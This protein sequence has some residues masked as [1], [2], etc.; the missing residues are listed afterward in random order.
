MKESR[1]GRVRRDGCGGGKGEERVGREHGEGM[2]GGKVRG[3]GG[4]G[5]CGEE[6][7]GVG[8]GR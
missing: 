3:V 6:R 1:G 5:K 4:R 2:W 8:E 7:R